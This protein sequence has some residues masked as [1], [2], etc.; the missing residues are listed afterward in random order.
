IEAVLADATTIAHLKIG[1]TGNGRSNKPRLIAEAL[2]AVAANKDF[3]KLGV[4][5]QKRLASV[6][7]EQ[8][9]RHLATHLEAALSDAPLKTVVKINKTH[10]RTDES[11]Q[12]TIILVERPQA[13]E[14]TS[15]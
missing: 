12:I 13:A 6:V 9:T 5:R 1:G 3:D 15:E 2:Q 8:L 7:A 14:T 11:W 10:L 4:Y